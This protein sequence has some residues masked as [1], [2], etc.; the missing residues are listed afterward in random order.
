MKIIKHGNRRFR[1]FTCPNC[2]CEFVVDTTE[3]RVIECNGITMWYTT[4]CPECCYD[5]TSSEPW[6]EIDDRS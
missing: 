1:K 5:T 2:G 6:D 4:E 3:Y